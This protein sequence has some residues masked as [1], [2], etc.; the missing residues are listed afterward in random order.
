MRV[1]ANWYVGVR[2]AQQPAQN[3]GFVGWLR[4]AREKSEAPVL[5]MME[6]CCHG[7][8]ETVRE[9]VE[10]HDS[11]SLVGVLKDRMDFLG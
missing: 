9:V 4:W 5:R 10:H 3:V 11:R 6:L 2:V 8:P 1:G 7:V